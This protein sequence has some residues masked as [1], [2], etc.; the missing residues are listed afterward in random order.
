MD[1]AAESDEII[2]LQFE[3]FIN[4]IDDELLNVKDEETVWECCLRWL[5]HN[6]V[7]RQRYVTQLLKAVRLGLLNTNVMSSFFIANVI[8]FNYIFQYFNERVKDNPYVMANDEAKPII[9]ETLT[10]LYDLDV[11]NSTTNEVTTPDLA[12]PR[13]PHEVIFAIGGWSEGAPQ[14]Y[15]ETYDTRADRWVRV[16]EEDPAGPRAYHGTA[17]IGYKIYCIGGFDGVEYFNTCRCF[18]GV[19][20]EWHEIAPMHCKRCYVSVATYDNY[21]YAMGGYD[22]SNRQN[23]VERYN[24]HTNQWTMMTPMHAQRSDASACCLDGK[25]YITGG[26]N[27]QECLNTSEVLDPATNLWTVLPTML[28]RRSGVSCVAH[29]GKIYCIGGFN[30]LSRMKSGEKFDPDTGLW[31]PIREMYHA[32]SNFGLEIIDDMIFAIGG[33]NG[34]VTISHAECYVPETNE[35]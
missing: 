28:Q 21:I 33:F 11:M 18:D 10:F 19:T 22:G 16:F 17:V 29:K 30:G 32:R 24:I 5:D 2:L 13:L 31:A 15:I 7:E 23:T 8:K 4:V 6:P 35:W 25:I 14:S 3:E 20:K 12:M 26:F 27:G 34:V 1:I 9:I